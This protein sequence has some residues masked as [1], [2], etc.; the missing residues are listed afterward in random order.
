MR[1]RTHALPVALVLGAVASSA[2]A[3]EPA[4]VTPAPATPA[5]PAPAFHAAL[6]TRPAD[7]LWIDPEERV[8]IW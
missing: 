3:Q 8:R 7:G 2:V 1:R 4:P 5:V 6:G